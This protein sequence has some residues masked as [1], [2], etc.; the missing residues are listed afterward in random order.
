MTEVRRFF[1]DYKA[2]ENKK[3]VVERFLERD[4]AIAILR[5]AINLYRQKK[6]ELI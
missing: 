3:V 1:E 4:E 2:L 6:A 5:D